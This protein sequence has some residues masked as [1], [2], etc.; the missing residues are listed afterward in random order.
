MILLFWFLSLANAALCTDRYTVT[1]Q[2]K[3]LQQAQFAGYVAA[4][5]LGFYN[6]ECIQIN[7]RPGGSYVDPIA[8]IT[9]GRSQFAITWLSNAVLAKSLGMNIT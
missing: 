5:G 8:E 2:L 3:W 6:D 7:I 4:E 9:S 1:L